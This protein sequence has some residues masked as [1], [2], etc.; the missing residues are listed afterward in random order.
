MKTLVLAWAAGLLGLTRAVRKEV[1]GALS[2]G[3]MGP[4]LQSDGI[5]PAI[6]NGGANADTARRRCRANGCTL[7]VNG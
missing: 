7:P 6:L 2:Q 1:T 4:F 5:D 3:P